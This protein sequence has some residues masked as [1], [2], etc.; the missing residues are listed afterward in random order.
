MSI[1]KWAQRLR[2]FQQNPA[3]GTPKTPKSRVSGVLGVGGG[4]VPGKNEGQSCDGCRH[5]S[6]DRACLEPEAA[7]LADKALP[8]WCD[9]MNGHGR[10]CPAFEPKE[11]THD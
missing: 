4:G 1:G 5:M 7:G 10:I 9:L 11:A 6:P 2:D 3:N 8:R